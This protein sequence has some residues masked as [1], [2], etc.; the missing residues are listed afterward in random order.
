M[1][2]PSA[3][4]TIEIFTAMGPKRDGGLWKGST[5]LRGLKRLNRTKAV[6]L[7]RKKN[8]GIMMKTNVTIELSFD[9]DTVTAVDVVNRIKELIENDSLSLKFVDCWC[10]MYIDGVKEG[11]KRNS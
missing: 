11:Q 8:R 1:P 5:R 7:R 10:P 2:S 4:T 3:T 9:S 6:A